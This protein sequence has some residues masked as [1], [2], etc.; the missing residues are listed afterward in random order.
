MNKDKKIVSREIGVEIASICSKYFLKS[1]H[2]H[3]GYWTSDLE[4]DITNLGIAQK[5]YAKFLISHIP[6]GVSR[7]LD[8]GCGSGQIAKILLNLGYQVDCVSPS[9]YLSKQARQLL[10]AK[11]H[12]FECF[13]EELETENRYDLI[14]FS[15]SFQYIDQEEAI[16]KTFG[17]LK[18]GGYVL[19]C[20]IFKKDTP[21]KSPLPGGHPLRKFYDIVSEYSLEPVE[22]LDITAQTAPTL[23]VA[24]DMLSEVVK[25]TVDLTQQLLNDRYP[26]MSKLLKFLYR[27]RISKISKKYFSGVKTGENFRKFK[28]Y[29]LLLYKKIGLEKAGQLDFEDAYPS[30]IPLN[31]KEKIKLSAITTLANSKG[32]NRILNYLGKKR[33]LALKLAFLILIIEDIITGKKP[34][35]LN[36]FENPSGM[37]IIGL[38]LVL[39]GALIRFWARG[40]FVK[41]HLFTTGPYAL[42][43]HPLYFGS[44]LIVCGV[45]FQLNDWLNWA[46]ILP[47]FT[48]FYGAAI[49][50]EERVLSKRFGRE[51]D[52]YRAKVHA[53][54]PSLRNLPLPRPSVKWSWRMYLNTPEVKATLWLLTLPL[55]IELIEDLVF[56]R[57]L[58]I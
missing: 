53:V 45:L 55:W 21:G 29:R 1:Q 20:D 16:R 42:V 5:N 25:P 14:F 3:Y 24:N 35:E 26:F 52:L 49:I 43:R 33:T 58:G 31:F 11:S 15:E 37:A 17:L 4:V 12:I 28:S 44:F 54:I 18:K 13:Y 38:I 22:D 27:K 41:G 32:F 19:I 40:H 36:P 6:D 47:L 50:Y 48:L 7:I 57:M 9:P 2:L 23:D 10:G 56:E 30:T 8:V 34:N 46:I 39:T 51:W